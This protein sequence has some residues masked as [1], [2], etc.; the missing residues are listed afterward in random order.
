VTLTDLH[1]TVI[2][3][4]IGP[5]SR[6][7]KPDDEATLQRLAARY[8]AGLSVRQLSAETGWS[9]GTVYHRLSMAQVAGLVVLRPRGGQS[10]DR[11]AR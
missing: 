1:A 6:T 5:T 10:A 7:R 9:Y 2:G 3:M 11:R 8:A 4:K